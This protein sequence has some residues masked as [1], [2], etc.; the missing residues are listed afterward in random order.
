MFGAAAVGGA[1]A[2]A[3]AVGQSTVTLPE[4]AATAALGEAD[5]TK[6]R[7]VL[8]SIVA[9]SW[10]AGKHAAHVQTKQTLHVVDWDAW[11]PG[12]PDAAALADDG[13]FQ[14][15][16]QT[17]GIRLQGIADS[18]AR[19][20]GDHIADGLRTGRS[21]DQISRTLW[22][23]VAS[24]SRAEM[25]AHTETARA[26]SLAT[27]GVYRQSGVAG[28]DLITSP[29]A[30]PVCLGV[31]AA[32]PHPVS[33]TADLSPLHPRCRCAPSPHVD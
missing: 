16:L 32:N 17:E 30:C 15:M 3:R 28:W 5:T 9:D 27:V 25:I 10:Q 7:Y 18:T 22:P 19:L 13:G 23:H 14:V 26:M 1:V 2:A 21:V 24:A 31:A 20:I 11:K 12:H 33:D 4:Q 8:R 29:G 6:L